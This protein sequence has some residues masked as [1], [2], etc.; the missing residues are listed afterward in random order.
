MQYKSLGE[1]VTIKG[2]LLR[3]HAKFL[4]DTV[5]K[6]EEHRVVEELLITEDRLA[7]KYPYL[8]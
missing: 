6:I 5:S 2:M 1:D 4:K 8:L 3:R 7:D